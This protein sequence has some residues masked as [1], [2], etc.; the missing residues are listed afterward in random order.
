M[1]LLLTS[2]QLPLDRLLLR[3]IS[4]YGDNRFNVSAVSRD[5]TDNH[6]PPFGRAFRSWA[7]FRKSADTAIDCARKRLLDRRPSSVRPTRSPDGALDRVEVVDLHQGA[8]GLVDREDG[9]CLR[10]Y[11]DAVGAQEKKTK[12]NVIE[13]H[14]GQVHPKSGRLAVDRSGLFPAHA[15]DK[16]SPRL[17]APQ[18]LLP[19]LTSK[20]RAWLI[21][22]FTIS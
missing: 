4:G 3:Y 6:V 19:A 10:K 20:N 21:T 18:A 15:S 2:R 12:P 7:K 5:R 16:L 22:A 8:P 17:S 14:V 9:A 1:K 11:L 13:G